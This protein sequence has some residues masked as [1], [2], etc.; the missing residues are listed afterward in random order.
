MVPPMPDAP[1]PREK[2]ANPFK[3]KTGIARIA[4]ALLNSMAGLACAWR[5]ES[6]FRQEVLLAAVMIPIALW[7]PVLP[8]ER[9]LLVATVLLVLVVELVNS[10]IES[11]ID[12][13]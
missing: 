6:A 4:Q 12:R 1:P 5:V 13:I 10:A 3:R 8:V 9:A 11:A 2:T 7:V